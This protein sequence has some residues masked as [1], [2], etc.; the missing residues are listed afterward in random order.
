MQ[1]K[2]NSPWIVEGVV[3]HS[4]RSRQVSGLHAITGWSLH[5]AV[6]VPA[7]RLSM[8]PCPDAQLIDQGG[9]I[10]LNRTNDVI[11]GTIIPQNR[12]RDLIAFSRFVRLNVSDDSPSQGIARRM[13]KTA[14]KCV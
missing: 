8:A 1:S 7:H 3:E 4:A 14:K 5:C 6:Q 2:E 12:A 9:D 10:H 13:G 11:L